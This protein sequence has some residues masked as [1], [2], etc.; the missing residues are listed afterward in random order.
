M[1]RSLKGTLGL[2]LMIAMFVTAC[3]SAP[4]AQ[5]K[6][7]WKNGTHE[8]LAHK[9][10][11]IGVAKDAAN[12]KAF[13]DSFVRELNSRGADAIASYTALP[14]GK[15]NDP[16]TIAQ[17][18]EEQAADAVLV[19]RRLNKRDAQIY[20]PGTIFEPNIYYD[21]WV[22]YFGYGYQALFM[23]GALA[24]DEAALM[25]TNVYDAANKNLIWS[26]TS[27]TEMTAVD[28]ATVRAT[29]GAMVSSMAGQK[30]LSK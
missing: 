25:E 22:D 30:L 21:T 5:L 23:R 3:A 1:M 18:I 9:I 10:M 15:Q 27:E 19:T 29:A 7:A 13:E 4:P 17:K 6:S 11:V 26:G 16:V 20:V 14:E 8:K 24:D 2:G 12:R 28:H